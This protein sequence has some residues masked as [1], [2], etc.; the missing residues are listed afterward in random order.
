MNGTAACLR[1]ML[2]TAPSRCR[3]RRRIPRPSLVAFPLQSAANQS[4][5]SLMERKMHLWKKAC[6]A[7]AIL[8]VMVSSAL[9]DALDA[10]KL[11][12]KLLV[13]VSEATPPFSFR[14]PGEN[15][16][17]GYDIDLVQAVTKRIGVALELM[18]LSS[19]SHASKRRSTKR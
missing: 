4:V 13:G 5:T 16:I 1:L 6:A 7:A 15:T 10:I 18:P 12:G 3:S 2:W 8:A 14:R 11:R 19:A 9:T 17:T